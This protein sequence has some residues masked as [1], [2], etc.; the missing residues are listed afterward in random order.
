MIRSPKEDPDLY[1]DQDCRPPRESSVR[2]IPPW[3]T[4]KAP[5]KAGE[6]RTDAELGDDDL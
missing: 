2:S 4:E 1:D 3:M 5:A 6:G